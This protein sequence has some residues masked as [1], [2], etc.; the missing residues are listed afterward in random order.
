ML[1][2]SLSYDIVDFVDY[3]SQEQPMAKRAVIVLVL[4]MSLAFA[5]WGC[6]PS[7]A[8]SATE[9]TPT[10]SNEFSILTGL[11]GSV[12]VLPTGSTTWTEAHVGMNL[13]SGDRLRTGANSS[14]LITFFEG[15]TIELE[16]DTEVGIEELTTSLETQSTTI[17]LEQTLGKTRSRVEKLIDPASRYEIT[18]PSG[19][20]V[21]RGTEFTV[22][23]FLDGTTVVTVIEGSLLVVA[24]VKVVVSQK[25]GGVMTTQTIEVLLSAGQ[26]TTF[27]PTAPPSTNSSG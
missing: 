1:T 18:T 12:T 16:S 13:T 23:V 27:S 4:A 21:V 9:P 20:A 17:G 26:Q 10:V 15:S 6:T 25:G 11:S 2:P 8:P 19:S 5:A 22:E 3:L 14:A 24:R 7:A